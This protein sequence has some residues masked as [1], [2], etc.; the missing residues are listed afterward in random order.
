MVAGG[1]YDGAFRG[2]RARRFA[3]FVV[4]RV[5]VGKLVALIDGLFAA[6]TSVE[7]GR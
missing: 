2:R 3:L 6:D 7:F 5:V 4:A 1:E